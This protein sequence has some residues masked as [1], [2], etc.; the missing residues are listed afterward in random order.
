ME[1]LETDDPNNNN[2]HKGK[3]NLRLCECEQITYEMNA[4]KPKPKMQNKTLVLVP[5]KI[6]YDF[7]NFSSSEN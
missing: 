4:W 3:Y 7:F 6:S 1:R 2:L 5:D